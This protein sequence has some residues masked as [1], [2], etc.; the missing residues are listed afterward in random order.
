MVNFF[1]FVENLRWPRCL[2]LGKLPS[3]WWSDAEV[4]FQASFF[5][6][7]IVSSEYKNMELVKKIFWI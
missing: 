5:I 3:F 1:G 2:H 4:R 7:P 6:D